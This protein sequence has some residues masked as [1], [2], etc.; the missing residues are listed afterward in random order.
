MMWRIVP[1]SEKPLED[2]KEIWWN[3]IGVLQRTHWP[4]S[5]KGTEG[6]AVEKSLLWPK[7]VLRTETWAS[8]GFCERH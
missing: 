3:L 4:W 7:R 2:F 1:C 8:C 6:K 5:R